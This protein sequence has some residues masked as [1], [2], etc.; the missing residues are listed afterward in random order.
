MRE[1]VDRY[2]EERQM[3]DLA[4]RL[5]GHGARTHTIARWTGLPPRRIRTLMRRFAPRQQEGRLRR[6]RGK[7]PYKTELLLRSRIKHYAAAMFVRTCL[8]LRLIEVSRAGA[9][10]ASPP[11]VSWGERFCGAFE[12]F[13][14]RYPQARLNIEEAMLLLAAL[15]TRREY[16]L[17]SCERCSGPVLRDRFALGAAQ[18]MTCQQPAEISAGVERGVL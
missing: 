10:A 11:D 15:T 9:R 2:W 1:P 4:W 5:L 6:P 18:C 17:E 14:S 3:L 8:Q 16:V 12:T 7:S 13:A